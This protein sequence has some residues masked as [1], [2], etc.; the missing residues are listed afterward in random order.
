ME[1]L[2]LFRTSVEMTLTIGNA[3]ADYNGQVNY[4]K[5]SNALS[6]LSMQTTINLTAQFTI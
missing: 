2:H 1:E 3:P 5:Q 6:S 4:V